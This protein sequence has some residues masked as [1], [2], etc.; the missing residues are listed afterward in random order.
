M[1][2]IVM[3]ISLKLEQSKNPTQSLH[4]RKELH[5][6]EDALTVKVLVS[7]YSP[8]GKS[9]VKLAL[10]APPEFVPVHRVSKPV[11]KEKLDWITS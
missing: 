1:C 7:V 8:T 2:Q 11:A 3:V 6:M 10:I 9:K 4:A 5:K